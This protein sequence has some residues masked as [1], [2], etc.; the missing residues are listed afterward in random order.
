M[1]GL[2]AAGDRDERLYPPGPAA[3]QGDGMKVTRPLMILAAVALT[4]AGCASTATEPPESSATAPSILAAYGLAGLDGPAIVDRLDR[5]PVASR[6]ATLRA[7]VRPGQLL[8]SEVDS[9]QQ[10]TVDLP[11]DLFYLAVAPYIEKTH[12]CY[13]HSLTTCRGEL[14]GKNIHVTITERTTGKVLVDTTTTTFDN[15]FAGFWLPRGIDAT[16]TVTYE[17]Y[18]ATGDISTGPEDPTCLTT[19]RLVRTT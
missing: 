17:T 3:R 16:I 15:G 2:V 13:F 12:D 11:D 19:L 8:L 4:L 14:A 6:P 10:T 1:A 7:S 9:G 18:A 5:T